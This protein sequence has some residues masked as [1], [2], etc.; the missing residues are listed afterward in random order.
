MNKTLDV[1]SWLVFLHL[2]C[3]NLINRCISASNL[4]THS[5]GRLP[6]CDTIV[7]LPNCLVLTSMTIYIEKE[8]M[9]LKSAYFLSKDISRGP[10]VT[11][12]LLWWIL[13]PPLHMHSCTTHAHTHTHIHMHAHTQTHMHAHTQTHMH[14]H[15]YTEHTHTYTEHTHTHTYTEHT[16]THAHAHWTRD[17]NELQ[18][19]Y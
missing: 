17:P 7:L 1:E 6:Q 5:I 12:H 11:G 4:A 8:S 2:F 15:T 9:A 18:L 19:N 3:T 16:H 13:D 14:A 10:P